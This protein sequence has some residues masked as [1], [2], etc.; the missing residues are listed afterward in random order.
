VVP[1]SIPVCDQ[2][3]AHRGGLGRDAPPVVEGREIMEKRAMT[4]S[5]RRFVGVTGG[6]AATLALLGPA[7]AFANASDGPYGSLVPDPGEV[8]DLP[9]GFQ[10]RVLSQEGSPT[11]RNKATKGIPVPGSH[12]GTAAFAGPGNTTVLVRNHEQA[13]APARPS[14][15]RTRTPRSRAAR[16]R[17]SSARTAR[18]STRT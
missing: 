15:A 4:M 17:S 2:A 16:R 7:R 12:D 13:G 14:S 1:G 11:M 10:Y 8:L 3:D 9:P 5:R 6:A 18:S